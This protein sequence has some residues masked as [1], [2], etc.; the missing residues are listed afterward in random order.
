M[1]Q[2]LRGAWG[3]WRENS[4]QYKIDRALYRMANPRDMEGS[5]DHRRKP[6]QGGRRTVVDLGA[7]EHLPEPH[8]HTPPPEQRSD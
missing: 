4:R 8:K 3:R 5:E 6:T 7:G 2:K 1:L